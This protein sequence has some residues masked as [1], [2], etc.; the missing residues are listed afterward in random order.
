MRAVRLFPRWLGISVAV[1]MA[2]G[3]PAAAVA[4]GLTATLSAPTHY[5]K[6]N[7]PFRITVRASRNGRPVSGVVSYRYLSYGQQVATRPG[8]KMRNGVYRDT[9]TWP[10]AAVGHPLTW[11][12]VVRTA[13]GT[14]Y[15]S[16]FIKV[17]R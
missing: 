3:L 8:G 7:T 5:P 12:V 14:R 16:Y 15:I 13:Y 9:I 6:F 11:Q 10:R 4:A 17:H 2:L 1:V